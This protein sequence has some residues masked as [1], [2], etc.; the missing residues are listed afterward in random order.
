MRW[1]LGGE[2]QRGGLGWASARPPTCLQTAPLSARVPRAPAPP[3]PRTPG[4]PPVAQS[5]KPDAAADS[6]D[7]LRRPFFC[8]IS[9]MV[10]K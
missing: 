2:G 5:I 1:A 4:A 3:P 8:G 10:A 9:R 7:G 6:Q